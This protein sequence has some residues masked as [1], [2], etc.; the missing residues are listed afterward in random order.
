MPDSELSR[1]ADFRRLARCD[2]LSDAA[3]NVFM[4]SEN[5]SR[6]RPGVKPMLAMFALVSNCARLCSAAVDSTRVPSIK[7]SA[8]E[9]PRR[10]PEGPAA[11]SAAYKSFQAYSIWLWCGRGANRRGE[12]T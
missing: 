6:L 3:E 2:G 8:P 1:N 7:S 10:I 9:T 11:S 4:K 5:E 12:R